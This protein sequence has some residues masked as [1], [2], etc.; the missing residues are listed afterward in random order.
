MLNV[1]KYRLAVVGL[2]WAFVFPAAIASG[3]EEARGPLQP[4]DTSSPAATLNSL[5]D[6]CNELQKLIEVGAMSEDREGEILPTAERILD[7]LDLSELPKELRMTAGIESA[8]FLK[9]VLDRIELPADEEIPKPVDPESADE[10]PPLL[11]WQI[12]RTRILIAQVKEGSR[13]N[14]FLF[15]PE[16]VREASQFYRIVKGLPYRI[17]GRPVSQGLYDTYLAA[18][19]KI[20]SYTAETSS[21]RGT[22]TLFLD[23]C[24]ELNEEIGK[25]RYLARSHPDFQRL[26][27]QII[28]C[29]DT[30]KLPD[31][32]REYF[33]AE[34]AVCLKEVLDRIPLPTAEEIP[35]IGSVEASDG[36]EALTRWQ[37]PRTQIVISKMDEGPRRGEFLFSFETVSRA[38]EFY[39][40]VASQPYRKEGRPVSEG[41]Y[42]WWLSR[43]GNPVVAKWVDQLPNWFQDRYFGMAIWQWISLLLAAPG[44]LV[45]MMIA[46]RLDRTRD[47][48][49]RGRT[50]VW[51]WLTLVF[52]VIAV[53]IPLGF[54]HFVWEYLSLR[55]SAV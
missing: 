47:E 40:K 49:M 17:D 42:D 41:F 26:G 15:T 25:D 21:P 39:R 38:P 48:Q 55:G 32:S 6:S 34:A 3:Q 45:L 7:C 22:M 4:S 44:G 37:V 24:N 29:L 12:P 27:N 23:S 20:P 14:A 31:F 2:L 16:T 51:H 35:G 33:D 8:L 43:P 19:K 53:L 54:K 36:S 52:P 18:T 1:T 30:S 28:S 9:E 5:I 10:S 11:H 13:Q 50:L 46:F